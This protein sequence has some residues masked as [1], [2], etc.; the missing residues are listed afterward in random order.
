MSE[1]AAKSWQRAQVRCLAGHRENERPISFVVNERDIEVRSILDS[2][3]EPDYL[4]FKVE[5]DDGRVYDLRHH[6]YEDSWQV[7]ELAHRL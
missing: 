5:T 1:I 6:E 7:R 4:C 2:W 3:R